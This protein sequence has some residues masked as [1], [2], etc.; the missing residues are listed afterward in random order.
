[1]H[2][3][4]TAEL[5]ELQRSSPAEA[6]AVR[7]ALAILRAEGPTLG[8]PWSS[9][10][11]GG[12][13]LR[14]LRPRRGRSPWRILYRRSPAGLVVLAIAPEAGVDRR[15]FARALDHAAARAHD[16]EGGK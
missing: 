16:R 13:G 5:A 4:F 11:R 3:S 8:F 7:N 14:E 12:G 2:P 10:V 15:G 6:R 1:M 9:A